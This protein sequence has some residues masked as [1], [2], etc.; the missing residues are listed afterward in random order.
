MWLC[1]DQGMCANR[2]G[3][4]GSTADL[5]VIAGWGPLLGIK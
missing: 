4:R 2:L 3:S 5:A 1:L